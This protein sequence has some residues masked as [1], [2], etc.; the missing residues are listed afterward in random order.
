MNLKKMKKFVSVLAL[1]TL[2]ATLCFGC[3]K[4][5]NNNPDVDIQPDTNTPA[6]ADID[7]PVANPVVDDE[8]DDTTNETY[9]ESK[10]GFYR[11]ELT[12]EW[13]DDRRYITE[14]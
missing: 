6:V 14:G 4:G 7:I 5:N 10:E 8:P 3:D 11:S 13:I 1:V 2:S 12:N 9:E